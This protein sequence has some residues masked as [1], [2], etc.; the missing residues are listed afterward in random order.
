MIKN[1]PQRCDFSCGPYKGYCGRAEYDAG[2]GIFHGEVLGTRDVITFQAKEFKDL[3]VVFQESVDDYLAFCQDSG[4][5]PEKPFS[6]K[7]VARLNPELH[8]Q[9]AFLAEASGKSLNQF[10][11]D[12]LEAFT[13]DG[14]PASFSPGS[15]ATAR[16]RK[17]KQTHKRKRRQPVS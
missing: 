5:P 12:C 2:E 6:G 13:K 14:V 16:V 8:R 4:E 10:V 1:I 17:R 11:S 15:T 3:A 9:V 7:F